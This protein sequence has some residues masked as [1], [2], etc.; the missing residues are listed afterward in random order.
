[1]ALADSGFEAVQKFNQ[2]PIVVDV[3]PGSA[4][5]RAGLKPEDAIL[6]VNGQPVGR[7]FERAIAK[8]GAGETL[9]LSVRREGAEHVLEWK[10]ASRTQSVFQL[11]DVPGVT[12]QQRQRRAAWLFDK[13]ENKPQ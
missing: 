9:R 4:A 8:V 7:D 6:R 1:M 13:S 10:L 3:R 5:D 12:A 11:K 2:P